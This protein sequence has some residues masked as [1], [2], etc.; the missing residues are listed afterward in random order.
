MKKVIYSLYIDIPENELVPHR[1][2]FWHLE[3]KDKNVVTKEELKKHYQRLFKCKI[4]YANHLG[5]DFK[6]FEVDKMY[7]DFKKYIQ[8][9][10]PEIKSYDII[11]FYKIHLL[12]KLAETYDEILYLDF[13]TIPTT[14]ESFFE[15]WNFKNG[16]CVLDNTHK[17]KEF[18]QI[19][20]PQSIRSPT[21]KYYNAQAMLIERGF[22][23]FNKVINTGIIGIDKDHLTKLAYFD[24]FKEDIDLMTSLRK[25]IDLFPK[26][27]VESFG[28]DNE[29]LFSY[30]LFSKDIKTQWLDDE[31]HF[32]YDTEFHIPKN[33]KIIHAINKKFD[34]VWRYYDKN[35]HGLF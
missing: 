23:P 29:T 3:K 30:H 10:F 6:M 25:Q 35:M 33:R 12:Y 9:N 19:Y 5:V 4:D 17:I 2:M 16:V 18:R 32:F 8:S 31:W 1:P 11:N 34:F 22:N 28:Y 13:D 26:K 21:A 20:Q 15:K 24:N 7:I 27:V 14:S